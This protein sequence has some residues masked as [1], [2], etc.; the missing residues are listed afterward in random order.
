MLEH[1]FVTSRIQLG[2]E[3]MPLTLSVGISKKQGLPDYGSLGASC[4]VQ[5][6]M[7]SALLQDLDA[8]HRQ[9]RNAYISCTQ[10]VNDELVRQQS[11]SHL[12]ASNTSVVAERS[13]AENGSTNGFSHQGKSQTNGHGAQRASQKQTEY[14]NQLARQVKGL[15]VRRL[16]GLATK[17]FGKPMTDLTSM[18]ASGLIDIIKAIKEGRISLEDALGGVAT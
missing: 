9:V 14:I 16:E 15:G 17:M 10:A 6:E 8:F 11:S 5:V 13:Y 18:D 4:N 2:D 1:A 7:E 3:P 12:T